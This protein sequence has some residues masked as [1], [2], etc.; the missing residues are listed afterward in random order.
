MDGFTKSSDYIEE[1][2]LDFTSHSEYPHPTPTEPSLHPQELPVNQANITTTFTT[3][4]DEMP[5][6]STSP[7][8]DISCLEVSLPPPLSTNLSGCGVFNNYLFRQDPTTGHLS[9]VPVQVRAPEALLGLDI[10]LSL[11]PQALQGLITVPES[12]DGPFI[13][14]LNVPVRPGPQ[15]YGPPSSCFNGSSIISYSPLEHSVPRAYNG[16]TNPGAQGESQSPS[17]FISPKVHP[18]LQEVIDLLRGEFSLD[19]YLDNGH[20]DIDMGMYLY[21]IT[22][23]HCFITVLFALHSN[24]MVKYLLY[25]FY[26]STPVITVT[27]GIT[28]SGCLSVCPFP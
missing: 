28:F 27:E 17:E 10:N 3:S 11:V 6:N 9:L 2:D 14:C 19:G 8:P 24:G 20:E 25:P 23:L 4:S 5:V 13:N 22:A 18:A 1:R 15:D 21:S 26:A 12:T 7:L 16:Q